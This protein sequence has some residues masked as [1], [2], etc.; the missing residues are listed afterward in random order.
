[1]SENKQL[2][3]F[4]GPTGMN[5]SLTS[6]AALVLPSSSFATSVN[7]LVKKMPSGIAG[8]YTSKTQQISNYITKMNMTLRQGHK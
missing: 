7:S 1:M 5:I 3:A 2:W 8:I 6:P 4:Y